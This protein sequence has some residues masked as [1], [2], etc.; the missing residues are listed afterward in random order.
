[1]KKYIYKLLTIGTI[2]TFLLTLTISSYGFQNPEK[3]LKFT[4]QQLNEQSVLAINWFQ[5]SG[6]YKALAYQAFNTAKFAFDYSISQNIDN[7]AVIVDIDETVLNNIYYNARLID[8]NSYFNLDTWNQWIKAQEATA[9][10][11]AV[12]FVNYV[13]S[14]GGKVFFISD[15]DQS[16]TK[17]TK[18]NDLELATIKNLQ[19]VGFTGVDESTVLLR[20]EFTETIKGKENVSKQLRRQAIENGQADGNNHKIVVLVG[21]NLNDFFE[22]NNNNNKIRRSYVENT[23]Y[24]YGVSHTDDDQPT[25]IVL[26]NPIYGAWESGL[27]KPQKFGKKEWLELTASEKNQQRKKALIPSFVD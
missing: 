21:D 24:Q 6:E 8:T 18:H 20:G 1:M 23:K 2:A 14:N 7:P 19:A 12:E 22:L 9:I 13:N 15:R 11:G 3:N 5:G 16:S 26:P 4:Q 10:P 27:Y 17:D 25:Y